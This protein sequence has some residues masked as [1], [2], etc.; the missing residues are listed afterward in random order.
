MDKSLKN[1]L[2]IISR[3]S[4]VNKS[5]VYQIF[6]SGILKALPSLISIYF[7]KSIVHNL[8]NNNNEMLLT[9][10]IA[11]VVINLIINSVFNIL[12]YKINSK[13]DMINKR[14]EE[15]IVEK[16]ATLDFWK[17]ED[18]KTLDMKQKAMESIVIQNIIYNVC[19]VFT[20]IVS[21]IIVLLT[22][23]TVIYTLNFYI[24]LLLLG[25][26]LINNFLFRKMQKYEYEMF[27]K[28]MPINRKY[29]YFFNMSTD[30]S[31]AK[32]IRLYK[33]QKI[34]MDKI[35]SFNEVSINSMS[36][37]F[38]NTSKVN[39]IMI[40]NQG[41]IMGFTYIYLIYSFNL[42]KI[43]IDE[44]F[45]YLSAVTLFSTTLGNIINTYTSSR[46]FSNFIENF[47]KY[48]EIEV[49]EYKNSNNISIEKEECEI[50]FKNVFFKYNSSTDY[51]L[52]NLSFKINNKETISIVGVNGCGKTTLIK[53]LLKLYKPEK[54]E[55]LLNGV[56]INDIDTKSY[57][58]NFGIVF[59]DFK[60]FSMT[61][62]ENISPYVDVEDS[63]ILEKINDC[64]FDIDK[65]SIN[66]IIY[67]NF[68]NSG[69]Q[70]SGGQEQSIAIARALNKKKEVIVM[71][72]P[73]SALDP[74]TESI[75]FD[76]VNELT[77]NKTTIFISHRLSSCKFAN[78]II[79]ME[80]GKVVDIGSHSDLINK[81]GIY[82]TLFNKQKAFYV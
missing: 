59:Q 53:L 36:K 2:Y 43:L 55:I 74:K 65:A 76:K 75:I 5:Y 34:V 41:I 67:K 1:I 16:T 60:L 57:F 42:N 7:L 56:N 14:F 10:I 28:L 45:M 33:A 22:L 37:I 13:K 18:P 71:D 47:K 79:V 31:Y 61:I 73:T 23:A 64:G 50:E 19:E 66:K 40:I 32:D 21:E 51:V 3:A 24:I 26:V 80:D 63:Y 6:L 54:G 9:V 8:V 17:I 62:K 11:F 4:E 46:H 39:S 69:V 78:K 30:F 68:D 82:S 15:L 52:K 27:D 12:T 35:K 72:E 77:K 25:I 48:M 29:F 58:E 20:K 49:E 38:R 81:E 70:L 44:F